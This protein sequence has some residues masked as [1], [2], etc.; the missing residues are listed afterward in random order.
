LCE[1]QEPGRAGGFLGGGLPGL[2]T[3]GAG[4]ALPYLGGKALMSGPMQ[5]ALIASAVRPGPSA[6]QAFAPSLIPAAIAVGY[7]R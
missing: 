2:A 4:I 5:R 1:G 6:G 7:R 3:A